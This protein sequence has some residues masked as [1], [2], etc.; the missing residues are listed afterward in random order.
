[1]YNIRSLV[2]LLSI[3]FL[4]TDLLGQAS[5]PTFHSFF[6]PV[7]EGWT[8]NSG[9]TYQ[10]GS[11][12]SPA[13]RLDASGQYV[14]I[15]FDDE[16]GELIY[17][18][19]GW[20]GGPT[21]SGTFNVLE[22]VNGTTWTTKRTFNTLNKDAYEQY[23][24]TLHYNSR[25]VRFLFANKGVGNVGLDEVSLS[26]RLAGDNAFMVLYYDGDEVLTNTQLVTGNAGTST[27]TIE[28]HG[29]EET[30]IIQQ[31]NISGEHADQFALSGMPATL[32]PGSSTT[33][34]LEFNPSG[35]GSRFATINILSNA[36]NSPHY[37]VNIY[38]IAGNFADEPAAQPLN[39][40]FEN[41]KSYTYDAAFSHANPQPESYLVLRSKGQA[42]IGSPADGNTY[43]VGDAIGNARV[44]HVGSDAAFTPS[45][46]V[47]GTTFHHSVFSFNGPDGYENYRQAGPLSGSV[48]TPANMTG[49]FYEGINSNSSTFV[50]DLQSKIR[51]H[52]PFAYANYTSVMIDGF[53]SLDTTGGNKVVYCVYSGYAHIYSGPFGWDGSPIGGTL[54]REHTFAH[55]WYPTH[56][57][58]SGFEYSDFYNLFPTHLQSA[59]IPRSNHP[60]GVVVNVTSSFLDGKLGRDALGN[61]VYEPR[62]SH[63]GDAARAMFYMVLRYH[64]TGGNEWYLPEQQNQDILKLWHFTD[65]PDAWE[66]ARNDY[67]W[68]NQGNRNPFIDSIHFA[69][70]IDFK[71]MQ[72]LSVEQIASPHLRASVFPNPAKDYIQLNLEVASPGVFKATL[73]SLTGIPLRSIQSSLNAGSE[74][75]Q[76]D[77]TGFPE[78]VYILYIIFKDQTHSIKVLKY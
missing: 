41:L 58:T 40:I 29:L 31:A 34:A 27:F 26:K 47:A 74:S 72:W 62:D 61:T 16:P 14:E 22:S 63:K 33:F 64:N 21:W 59:N 10:Q 18:L 52:T 6:G 56:P 39:L 24:D 32:A 48:T 1:M 70:K 45:G 12:D 57:S 28:N 73:H 53:E 37:L 8:I 9:G 30:L 13:C 65:P 25:Y 20:T 11:D 23:R 38:A 15:F 46:V 78:G 43:M 75:L 2:F 54:S 51:P 71:T 49:D 66:I 42:V 76:M 55:S 50:E 19:R 5:L 67:I 77:L 44:V 36:D 60:L 3:L 7:P 69:T 68:S 4:G 17:H 35:T